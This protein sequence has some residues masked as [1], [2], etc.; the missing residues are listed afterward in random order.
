MEEEG[1]K[2]DGICRRDLRVVQYL[3]R[4]WACLGC[5]WQSWLDPINDSHGW[6]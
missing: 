1:K 5:C 3:R 4:D 6:I 2:F